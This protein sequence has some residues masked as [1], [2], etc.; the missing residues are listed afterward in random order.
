M[1]SNDLTLLLPRSRLRQLARDWL[2][3]DAPSLDIAG[4]AACG[5]ASQSQ[6]AILLC[7]SAGVLAGSPFFQA[8]CEEAGC[9]VAWEQHDGEWLE[10]VTRVATV[11]GERLIVGGVNGVL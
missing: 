6:E 11:Q 5:G 1:A 10:P 7:K 8:V 4:W 2:A 3:E 9:S